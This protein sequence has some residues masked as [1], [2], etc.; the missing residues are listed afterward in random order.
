M[1]E[2][3]GASHCCPLPWAVHT[4]R[5]GVC[6]GS[7]RVCEDGSVGTGVCGGKNARSACW[8]FTSMSTALGSPYFQ[9]WGRC[10]VGESPVVQERTVQ[11][12][13]AVD[14][15]EKVTRAPAP[16]FSFTPPPFLPHH[17]AVA[18][19]IFSP[20]GHP[21]RM[22]PSPPF[23]SC[24]PPTLLPAHMRRLCHCVPSLQ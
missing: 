21:F 18:V 17:D 13:H 8:G 23:R 7:G 19:P 20:A 14:C 5:C 9:V 11:P 3:T 1:I 22:S 4:S 16:L 6:V 15:I 2:D 10:S 24:H 12:Y